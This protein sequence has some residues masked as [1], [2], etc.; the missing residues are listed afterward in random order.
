ML[1]FTNTNVIDG[2]GSAPIA[3]STVL[4]GGKK[5][6]AVGKDVPV[7]AG[8]TVID[9]KG[10]TLMPGLIDCHSHLGGREHPPGL[11]GAKISFNYAPMR[12]YALA[13]GVTTIR[14]CGDFL[15]DTIATRDMI[16]EGTLRGPG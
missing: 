5:I 10:K 7:P 6:A 4:V 15:H 11:D 3:G 9:L 16:N 14:S 1:A 13:G 2:T 12:D 8:A